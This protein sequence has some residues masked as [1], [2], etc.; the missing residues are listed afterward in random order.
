MKNISIPPP[1]YVFMARCSLKEM[2]RLILPLH[3]IWNNED[4]SAQVQLSVMN[5]VSHYEN[6]DFHGSENLVSGLWQHVAL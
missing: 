4:Q 5:Q 1:L 3:Y 2:D 6:Q